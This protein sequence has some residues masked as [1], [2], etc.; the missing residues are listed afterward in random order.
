ML[1]RSSRVLVRARNNHL[2]LLGEQVVGQV[3]DSLSS[4][5]V[6]VFHDLQIRDPKRKPRNIDHV[7]LTPAGVFVIETKTRRK[8]RGWVGTAKQANGSPST[9]IG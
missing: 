1:V 6:R 4:D 2:G 3:L 9:G 7:V 8:P 5:S